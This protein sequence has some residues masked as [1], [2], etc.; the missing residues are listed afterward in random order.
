MPLGPQAPNA[1]A[2]GAAGL[3][4]RGAAEVLGLKQITNEKDSKQQ[5]LSVSKVNPAC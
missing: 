5:S 1:G 4:A 2:I 3:P